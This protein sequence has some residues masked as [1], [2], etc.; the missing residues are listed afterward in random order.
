MA[1][2]NQRLPSFDSY[3]RNDSYQR[4]AW[5]CF[6]QLLGGTLP[7]FV[8]EDLACAKEDLMRPLYS[9]VENYQPRSQVAERVRELL[10]S[11]QP[12]EIVLGVRLAR[13]C[14]DDRTVYDEIRKLFLSIGLVAA[15]W[16][17]A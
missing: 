7:A 15:D 11:E 10:G 12:S 14:S 6:T 2:R 8:Y 17:E 1:S 9:F 13:I 4:L 3:P 16:W 5:W